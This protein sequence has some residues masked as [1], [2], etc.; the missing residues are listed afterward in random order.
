MIE[1]LIFRLR[2]YDKQKMKQINKSIYCIIC[3]IKNVFLKQIQILK[4]KK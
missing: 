4:N 2:L 1:N 3:N